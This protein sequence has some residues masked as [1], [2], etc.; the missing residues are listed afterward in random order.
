MGHA[1]SLGEL[2]GDAAVVHLSVGAVHVWCV[3][4]PRVATAGDAEASCRPHDELTSLRL[5]TM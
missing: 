4:L 3:C 1:R 2:P 5:A